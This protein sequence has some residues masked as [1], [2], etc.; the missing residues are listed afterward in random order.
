MFIL[1]RKEKDDDE[2]VEV[3]QK[4]SNNKAAEGEEQKA[5]LANGHVSNGVISNGS[6]ANGYPKNGYKTASASTTAS[7]L[8]NGSGASINGSV[9]ASAGNGSVCKNG[10]APLLA[11]GHSKMVGGELDAQL[12][13]RKLQQQQKCKI[14]TARS[15]S[16]NENRQ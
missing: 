2:V 14:T 5:L 11:N 16:S 15:Q 4:N 10:E 9:K 1:Q 6:V 12:T 13:Q 7:T 3:K 8:I